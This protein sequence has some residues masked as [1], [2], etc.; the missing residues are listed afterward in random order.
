MIP[1]SSRRTFIRGLP[2]GLAGLALGSAFWDRLIRRA[3]AQEATQQ[4]LL[5]WHVPDGTVPEWFFPDT[6]GALTIRSDRTN[7]LSGNT[8]NTAIPNADRPTFLLQ[9]LA[10][11]APQIT[12]VKGISNP[13]TADHVLSTQAVLTGEAVTKGNTGTSPSLD[14]LMSEANLTDNHIIPVLRTGAYGS[15]LS[16]T[17]TRDLCRPRND[18]N[19]FVEPSWQPL[20]DAR[21]M[22]DSLGGRATPSPGASGGMGGPTA[23]ELKARSR[24]AA[25]GAVSA[26]IAELRCAAGTL[27]A[28]RLEAYL[29][30]VERLE[31]LE[32]AV[33]AGGGG[34]VTTSA[35]ETTLDVNDAAVRAGQDDIE[36][37]PVMA[38][39]LRELVVSALALDYCPAVTLQWAASGLNKISGNTLTDYRYDFLPNLEYKGAGEHGLA[40]PEDQKFKDAGHTISAAVSTRDRVRIRRWLFE[41]LKLVLDR[42]ASVPEGSGTLLDHTT[43]LHT[44]EF[45][46]PNANSVAGQHSNR[47][48][49]YMLI[50][51][52]QTP[53]RTGQSLSV[54]RN[55]G[56]LLFT[57]AKGF[58]SNETKMGIGASTIDGILK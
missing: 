24:I 51:G 47:N 37:Y 3:A 54:S 39:F 11:Y 46:G 27:A 52:S 17:G 53:F 34:P 45:G 20:T 35:F 25:L 7:D 8:F 40:H 44:S 6:T 55:H 23:A 43:V 57:L 49:P 48:L 21:S 14:V 58:K 32:Q 1:V 36:Q 42:L 16:Y 31:S 22:L 13:G 18:A 12:I 56:E 9:P 30:E 4:R 41:Q 2:L 28:Q 26:R 10:A 15:K 19:T 50:A 29:A 33:L 38:P 5:V